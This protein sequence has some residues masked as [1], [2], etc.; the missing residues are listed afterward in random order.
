MTCLLVLKLLSL[1]LLL[2]HSTAATPF[3]SAAFGQG[4]GPIVFGDIVCSSTEEQIMNCTTQ[5]THNCVSHSNDV[6]V[7]CVASTSG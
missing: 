7:R 6:G 5:L 1:I 3:L 2:Y 4:D